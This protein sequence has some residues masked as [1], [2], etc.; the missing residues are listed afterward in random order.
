MRDRAAFADDGARWFRCCVLKRWSRIRENVARRTGQR[1]VGGN[2]D[3]P[4]AADHA[5]CDVSRGVAVRCTFVR[6]ELWI[7]AATL[8]HAVDDVERRIVRRE[9]QRRR[10]PTAGKCAEQP[11]RSVER[12]DRDRIRGGERDV[13][14]FAVGRVGECG[15]RRAVEPAAVRR[16]VYVGDAR[17]RRDV[18]NAERV[19]VGLRH[20]ELR[21]VSREQQRLRMLPHDDRSALC[22]RGDVDDR[23]GRCRP[24]RDEERLAVLCKCHARGV[25]AARAACCRSDTYRC[26]HRRR[27]EIDE[28]D[29]AREVAASGER[30]A[31]GRARNSGRPEA[32]R[33]HD[34]AVASPRGRVDM[35]E[36]IVRGGS[37]PETASRAVRQRRAV[38][39]RE[40]DVALVRE[41]AC[42][43]DRDTRRTGAALDDDKMRAV[44]RA[45]RAFGKRLGARNESRRRR[46][47]PFRRKRNLRAG[48]KCSGAT[49]DRNE[50]CE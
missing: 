26:T 13:Q 7:R 37:D 39:V 46:E 4:Y 50:A 6:L 9:R 38:D 41:I 35:H 40:R 47:P 33:Q 20:V 22:A 29:G 24:V 16:N 42:R 34:R 23:D 30:R 32:A 44:G 45:H 27:R 17:T 28:H 15:R 19:V 1:G 5:G 14:A 25:F 48:R 3:A 10:I 43:E 8:A 49:S 11:R 12:D 2:G 36:R 18:D 21:P 31:V